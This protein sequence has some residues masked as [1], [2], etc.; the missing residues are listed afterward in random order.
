MSLKLSPARVTVAQPGEM[1][2]P[3]EEPRNQLQNPHLKEC[4]KGGRGKKVSQCEM[5]CSLVS[6]NEGPRSL[7]MAARVKACVCACAMTPATRVWAAAWSPAKTA[8][9]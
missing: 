4:L 2:S 1:V 3:A 5:Y 8:A 9:V 6:G 7:L